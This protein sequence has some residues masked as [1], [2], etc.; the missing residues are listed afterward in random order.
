M[1]FDDI[2]QVQIV[3]PIVTAEARGQVAQGVDGAGAFV[4]QVG[5]LDQLVALREDRELACGV[6]K[7][8]AESGFAAT[9]VGFSSALVMGRAFRG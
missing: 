9:D 6:Q 2:G 1:L 8:R 3:R 5:E 4:D 7:R